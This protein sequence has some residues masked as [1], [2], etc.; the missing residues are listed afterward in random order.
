MKSEKDKVRGAF[1]GLAIGDAL[2]TTL[3]FKTPGTFEPILD[4]IG[5]GPFELKAG[6][7]TDDT[8]MALCMA[9]SL[10]DCGGIQLEDHLK[11]YIDWWNNGHNSVTGHCFDI[12]NTVRTALG[13]Y[14]CSGNIY[15]GSDSLMS[16]GNGSIMRLAPIPIYFRKWHLEEALNQCE[17]S[18]RTTHQADEC[19]IACR[20]FG[21]L[22]IRALNNE[23]SKENL[24][25]VSEKDG[26]QID[27]EN[28]APKVKSIAFGSY[29][30][31]PLPYIRGTGYVVDS[32]EAALWAFYYSESFEEGALK[33][34]NLG[35]DADTTGAVFGQ[36]AG[37]FYGYESIPAR[38]RAKLAWRKKILKI[39]DKLYLK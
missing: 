39:A 10:L 11:R 31:T 34:V 28:I 36:I 37:A 4:M 12:G 14:G 38:W 22:I 2:G 24:L 17:E 6:E 16:A 21:F 7:W 29:I 25:K 33:A 8:T 30:T 5:G 27:P 15:S 23:I 18:S 9:E 3:E 20:L 35:D 1:L 26:E 13:N 32:L 19:L